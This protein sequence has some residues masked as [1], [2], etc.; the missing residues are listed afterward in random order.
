MKRIFVIIAFAAM[1]MAC[2]GN[3][4]QNSECKEHKTECRDNKQECDKQDCNNKCDKQDCNNKCD[5]QDCS[6]K[7]D[8]QDCNNKC[9][10]QDCNNKCDKQDCA[11]SVAG[12]IHLDTDGFPN[13]VADLSKEWKYLGDKPAIIDFY[14]DWCGPCRM[15][16]PTIEKIAQKY[17][18]EL[19]IYKVNIDDNPELAQRFRISA[20]PT[21][22]FIPQKGEPVTE[23]GVIGMEGFE[24]YIKEVLLK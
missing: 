2:G 4:A 13:K 24:K 15:I 9:D 11:Q 14:A 12:C 19:Y 21:I 8:K 7:C 22:M 10:K 18:G 17:N 1:M 20:I 16:A 5:K 3:K 6:N 23:R